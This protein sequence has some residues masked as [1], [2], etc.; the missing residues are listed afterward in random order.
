MLCKHVTLTTTYSYDC[1]E[2]LFIA[3]LNLLH[4]LTNFS[5]Y[6]LRIDLEDWDGYSAY[7]FYRYGGC[8][9]IYITVYITFSLNHAVEVLWS[10]I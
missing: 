5:S 6:E 1:C 10:I 3:G 7:A 9:P 2:K 8:I 4:V